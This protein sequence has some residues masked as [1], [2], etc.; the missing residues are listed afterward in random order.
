M[1]KTCLSIDLRCPKPIPRHLYLLLKQLIPQTFITACWKKNWGY[2]N[3]RYVRGLLLITF[4]TLI[5]NWV[6]PAYSIEIEQTMVTMMSRKP[7]KA[8]TFSGLA[9]QGRWVELSEG[10]R[11]HQEPLG[12]HLSSTKTS[13]EWRNHTSRPLIF[14]QHHSISPQATCQ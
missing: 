5:L 11:V 7:T 8:L 12:Q 2:I 10:C 6:I 4:S 3:F 9:L 13:P 14:S 1:T